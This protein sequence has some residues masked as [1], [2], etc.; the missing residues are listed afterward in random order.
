[1]IHR[2]DLINCDAFNPNLY[3][4]DY[5]LTFRFY[6]HNMTCIACHDI[7]HFWRDYNT[8][9]SRTHE[10]YAQNYFLEIKLTYFLELDYDIHRPLVIWG[11]GYKGKKIAK[12]LIKNNVPFSWICDNPKKIGKT[13]YNQN[14]LPFSYLESL[15]NPQSI[16]TVANTK[17]QKDI[18]SY[19]KMLALH[20][21]KDYFF[22]C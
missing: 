13:I 1:M 5:D 9:T 15:S 11:A 18:K 22:F 14:M 8:R 4:E 7:L 2:E 16:I 19:F 6:K 12:L 20:A 17:A 3:P 10:H 21:S